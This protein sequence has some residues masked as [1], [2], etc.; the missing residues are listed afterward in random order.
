MSWNFALA[1]K[2]DLPQI[3]TAGE[4]EKNDLYIT[5]IIKW[6]TKCGFHIGIWYAIMFKWKHVVCLNN[7]CLQCM[8]STKQTMKSINLCMVWLGRGGGGGLYPFIP[9]LE[10]F[11]LEGVL[12]E[13]GDLIKAQSSNCSGLFLV[14]NIGWGPQLRFR[15]S[16][17]LGL[18]TV[19][20]HGLMVSVHVCHHHQANVTGVHCMCCTTAE[21]CR[22]VWSLCNDYNKDTIYRYNN[23][24]P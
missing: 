15:I 5:V 18:G 22:K 1:F 12:K 8:K 3:L 9:V 6:P 17:G 7:N 4:I 13:Y 21:G 14:K 19:L 16:V 23:S 20:S 11:K 24:L 2:T 10:P